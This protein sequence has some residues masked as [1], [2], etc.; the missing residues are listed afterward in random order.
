MGWEG[1]V[2]SDAVYS[3]KNN[4]GD[5]ENDH[6]GVAI[7]WGKWRVEGRNMCSTRWSCVGCSDLEDVSQDEGD[8]EEWAEDEED[9]NEKKK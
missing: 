4:S 5:G 6:A 9:E 3:S 8:G 7:A 2:P 1:E